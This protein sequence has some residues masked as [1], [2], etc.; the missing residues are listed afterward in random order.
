LLGPRYNSATTS[1]TNSLVKTKLTPEDIPDDLGPWK[2]TLLRLS[3]RVE[4]LEQQLQSLLKAKY[5]PKT[6]A[7]APNQLRLFG[8]SERPVEQEPKEEPATV[9]VQSSKRVQRKPGKELPRERVLH[10]PSEAELNCSCGQRKVR[11][12][13]E[14]TERLDYVPS[15]VFVKEHVRG[16]YAC[17]NCQGEVVIGPKPVQ[18]IEKGFVE[19]GMLA[20]IATS[21]YA[22]HLPL[23]RLESIFK[24]QGASI[25]RSTMCDW[26]IAGGKVLAP[27][28]ELMVQR[29]L[30]SRI[31][32][33][34]DTPV[35]MQDREL[36]KKLRETR[37]WTYL[38]DRDNPY[39]VFDFTKSRKRDGPAQFLKGYKGY[40]QADAFAGYDC[41]FAGGE[42]T[43]VA[44]MAHV[45]RKFFEAQ[46]SS[47]EAQQA[48]AII[49]DLY[50][51]E[52]N[53]KD[54]DSERRKEIRQNQSAALLQEFKAWLDRERL[55]ALPK[56]PI[57]KAVMYALNN[58]EALNRFIE[59]GNLTIDNN[60]AENALRKIAIGRKNW[61]FLGSESGGKTAS[62]F[63]S[64][65]A[66]CNRHAVD[67]CAY[68]KDVFSRLAANPD[69][70]LVTLLPDVWQRGQTEL[71][72]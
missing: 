59:D 37:L 12:G 42:V 30:Q 61:L 44:C 26:L 39:V 19:A 40:L 22:D 65:V 10:E 21:K 64:I 32:W 41:I 54:L 70:D 4:D 52:K 15:S 18:I 45:R 72:A 24:R 35:K 43:E 13:E 49:Q 11:I 9:V 38:G 6:E 29:V 58:W 33:T 17:K 1:G 47:K 8:E 55:I 67:P 69:V 46:T 62:I 71:A 5:G 23:H 31:I 56:S 14:V 34:D 51:I 25:A 57:G 7:I 36:E 48:L 50:L 3:G 68:L 60:R 2:E 27:L 28:H 66:T 20:Y 16:K 53:A 63:A